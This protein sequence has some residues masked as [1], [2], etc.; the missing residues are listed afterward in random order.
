MPTTNHLLQATLNRLAARFRQKLIDA[1]AHLA[2]ITKDAPEKI[3]TEWEQFQEEVA[4]EIDR[5]KQEPK[6]PEQ[7]RTN[8][9]QINIPRNDKNLEKIDHLRAKIADLGR[10]IEA[11]K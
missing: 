8:S 3:Q 9:T 5:L 6:G 1:A 10:K 2:V 7:E 4:L 11:K